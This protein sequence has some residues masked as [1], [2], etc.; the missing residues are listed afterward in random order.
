MAKKARPKKNNRGNF[1]GRTESFSFK[2]WAA[3]QK[4]NIKRGFNGEGHNKNAALRT[5][6]L[7]K[8]EKDF[9]TAGN[10][11]RLTRR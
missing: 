1:C 2:A 8:E 11:K 6:H 5:I 3:N 7:M 4:T 9:T 10:A